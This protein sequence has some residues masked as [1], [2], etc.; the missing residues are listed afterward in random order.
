MWLGKPEEEKAPCSPEQEARR[1]L[2]LS[3]EI[4]GRESEGITVNLVQYEYVPSSRVLPAFCKSN[5]AH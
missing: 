3:K 1:I 4:E 2:D 5:Y